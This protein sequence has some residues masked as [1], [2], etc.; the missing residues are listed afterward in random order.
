[1]TLPAS[2]SSV[3]AGLNMLLSAAGSSS[4][5]FDTAASDMAVPYLAAP[6]AAAAAAAAAAVLQ[7]AVCPMLGLVAALETPHLPLPF[8]VVVC[9]EGS[10]LGE[11]C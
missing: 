9:I 2:A 7:A 6:S 5:A 4:A 10:V 1:M 8:V 11:R 3:P